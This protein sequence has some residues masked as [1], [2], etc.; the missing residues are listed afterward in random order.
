MQSGNSHISILNRCTSRTFVLT[1]GLS[2]LLLAGP[3]AR[4]AHAAY[5]TLGWNNLGMHCL[6]AD[7]SVFCTLPP[8]NTI[9]AQVIDDQGQLVNIPG[10]ITVTYH[11]VADSNGSLNTTSADKTNFWQY[12]QP[13]FGAALPVDIGLPVPGPNSFTMPGAGNVPQSM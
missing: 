11:A 10:G 12:V 5:T 2:L 7:F 1:V 13:L 8:Y 3:T 4:Q 6:D 9:H